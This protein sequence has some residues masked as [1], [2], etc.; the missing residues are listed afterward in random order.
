MS[1][2][3]CRLYTPEAILSTPSHPHPTIPPCPLSGPTSN[4]VPKLYLGSSPVSLSGRLLGSK[5]EKKIIPV[6]S[7]SIAF[8]SITLCLWG[9]A[10]PQ[11]PT[12]STHPQGPQVASLGTLGAETAP[13]NLCPSCSTWMD[14]LETARALP[15]LLAQ[16]RAAVRLS[17]HQEWFI[18]GKSK[19]QRGKVTLPRS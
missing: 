6:T 7:H 1:L 19:A 13:L 14:S 3:L 17:G 5:L 2:K 11:I 16:L 12:P 8:L 9:E 10:I 18:A 4:P 15:G